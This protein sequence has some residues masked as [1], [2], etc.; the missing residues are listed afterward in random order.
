MECESVRVDVSSCSFETPGVVLVKVNTI[1]ENNDL[2][3]CDEWALEVDAHRGGV[4]GIHP[5]VVHMFTSEEI[6]IAGC[7][8]EHM[9]DDDVIVD[10]R[11]RITGGDVAVSRTLCDVLEPRRNAD[12]G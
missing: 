2:G 5:E 7:E 6:Q 3:R 9:N 8:C 4:I 12:V 10:T 1:E 11:C